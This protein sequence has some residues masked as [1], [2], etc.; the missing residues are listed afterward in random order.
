MIELIKFFI[1]LPIYLLIQV[2]FIG[3]SPILIILFLFDLP[4]LY[5]I[6]YGAKNM[7]EW[8]NRIKDIFIVPYRLIWGY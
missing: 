4:G 6:V 8:V 5:G 3:M 7:K 1:K 2:A